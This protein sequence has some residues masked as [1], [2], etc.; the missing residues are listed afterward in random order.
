MDLGSL[1][2]ADGARKKPGKRVGRGIGSG[3][4]KTAGR[5]TKGYG[6]RS[7]AKRRAW[8]EGGQMPIQRRLPK[9]GFYNKFR[10]EYQIVN[11]GDLVRI[12]SKEVTPEILEQS[13]LIK[14]ADELVKVLGDGE[15]PDGLTVK[16]HA[17][18][19]SAEDK[20]SAAGGSVE[21]L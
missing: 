8:F 12:D 1:K 13:G 20:I 19:K 21:R 5:G 9:R 7:G 11:V 14:H 15:A 18:S 16:A 4:G 3:K 17:F 6:S 2:Y 10:T